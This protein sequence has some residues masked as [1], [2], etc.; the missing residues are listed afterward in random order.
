MQG[1]YFRSFERYPFFFK[2]TKKACISFC[3]QKETTPKKERKTVLSSGAV[4][5]I[6]QI[7]YTTR[8]A[9]TISRISLLILALQR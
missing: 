7:A 8:F 4:C 2:R 6:F 1:Y 9:Q 5:Q 3:R